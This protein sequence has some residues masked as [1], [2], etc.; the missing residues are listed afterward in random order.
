MVKVTVMITL[1][2]TELFIFALAFIGVGMGIM[3]FRDY[4]I[5]RED[6]RF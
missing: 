1:H 4:L 6:G 5:G 3:V 2:Y